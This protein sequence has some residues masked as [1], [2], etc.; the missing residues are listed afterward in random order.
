MAWGYTVRGRIVDIKGHCSWGH[1][2][3]E[4]FDIDT[5]ETAHLC[6]W[7]Y[8]AIFPVLNMLEF[9]GGFPGLEGEDRD[10]VQFGCP[11]YRNVV[12]IELRRVMPKE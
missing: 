6:G 7:F 5:R 1:K 11:D 4:E 3:G 8:H 2:V 9:G 12:T 10:V